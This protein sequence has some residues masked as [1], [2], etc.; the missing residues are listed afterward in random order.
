MSDAKEQA[1]K[2]LDQLNVDGFLNSKKSRDGNGWHSRERESSLYNDWS[3]GE[4]GHGSDNEEGRQ[5][6]D[7]QRSRVFSL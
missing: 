4:G 1:Q 3:H 2:L 6:R 5:S 7:R